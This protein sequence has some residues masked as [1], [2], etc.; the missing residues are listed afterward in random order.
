MKNHTT[1]KEYMA[2]NSIGQVE[3]AKRLNLKTQ[4]AVSQMLASNRDIFIIETSDGLLA[5]EVK[6]IG[7]NRLKNT[8]LYW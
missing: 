4:S 8:K 3:I 5:Y 7:G 6:Q 1:L 2:T